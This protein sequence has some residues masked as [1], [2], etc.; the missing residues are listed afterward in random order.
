MKKEFIMFL[1]GI[2]VTISVAFTPEVQ[3]LITVKPTKPAVTIVQGFS[4]FHVQDRI[5][6]YIISKSKDG[7]IVKSVSISGTRSECNIGVVVMEKY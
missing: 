7:Y 6:D 3:K 2:F 5:T 4:D 1:L